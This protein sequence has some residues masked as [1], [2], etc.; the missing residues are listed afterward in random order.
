MN[1]PFFKIALLFFGLNLSPSSSLD[2]LLPTG[3]HSP[4]C[5][6]R[7]GGSANKTTILFPG[8]LFKH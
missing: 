2:I 6:W 8:I 3:N 1:K 5:C 4:G 7:I